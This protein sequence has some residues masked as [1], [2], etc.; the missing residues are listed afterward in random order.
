M[1]LGRP[2]TKTKAQALISMVQYYRDM[3]TRRS[4]VLA[5][6]TEADSGPKGRTILCNDSLEESFKELKCMVS[7]EMLLN[8]TYW[9]VPFTV[10]TNDFDTQLG[11]VISQNN[12]PISLF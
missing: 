10:H 2:T 1:D 6:L 5:P 9:T 11:D 7:S 12:K 4:H 8:Y 3:W